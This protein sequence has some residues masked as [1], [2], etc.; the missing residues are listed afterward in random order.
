[1][2]SQNP[3]ATAKPLITVKEARKLLGVSAKNLTNEEIKTMVRDYTSLAR[4]AVRDY[5]VRK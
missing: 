2:Q 1:M 4:Y 5:L 3:V